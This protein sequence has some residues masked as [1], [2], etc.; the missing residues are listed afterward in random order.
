MGLEN[1]NVSSRIVPQF[2]VKATSA[3]SG[4]V[5]EVVSTSSSPS[6]SSKTFFDKFKGT[7]D[8]RGESVAYTRKI[9]SAKEQVQEE[10]T[11]VV[12]PAV[13][14]SITEH[15]RKRSRVETR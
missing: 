9:E 14:E 15:E 5:E 7:F 11:D 10:K 13:D 12:R 6:F 2:E 4:I 8:I 3:L 1:N